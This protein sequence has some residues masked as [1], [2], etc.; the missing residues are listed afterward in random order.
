MKQEF[1]ATMPTSSPFS[2]FDP[3]VCLRAL[4]RS[5]LRIAVLAEVLK[6]ASPDEIVGLAPAFVREVATHREPRARRRRMALARTIDDGLVR[7]IL[8]WRALDGDSRAEVLR[9]GPERLLPVMRRL[10]GHSDPEA[11]F[12]VIR[13][14]VDMGDPRVAGDLAGLAGDGDVDVAR[15]AERALVTIARMAPERKDV[16]CASAASA[17]VD[18]ARRFGESHSS[19]GLLLSALLLTPPRLEGPASARQ[20][21]LA[22]WLMEADQ[23]GHSA[24]RTVLRRSPDPRVRLRAMHWMRWAPMS[25]SATARVGRAVGAE[26]HEVVLTVSHLVLHPV[27]AAG[28]RSAVVS[29]PRRSVRGVGSWPE[30]CALP[31]PEVAA[32]LSTAA[33]RGLARFAAVMAG[34]A[35]TLSV[36]LHHALADPDATVRWTAARTLPIAESADYCFDENPLV[37]RSTMLR[38]STVGDRS[39]VVSE[40]DARLVRLLTRHPEAAIRRLAKQEWARI[41]PW[42][43]RLASSRLAARRR[44]AAN[45]HGFLGEIQAAMRE[46]E[47]AVG[48]IMLVRALGIVREFEANLCAVV[49]GSSNDADSLRAIAAAVSAL[50]DLDSPAARATLLQCLGHH[51]DRVRANAVDALARRSLAPA[52]V[53]PHSLRGTLAEFKDDPSHRVRANAILALIRGVGRGI[54]ERVASPVVPTRALSAMLDDDRVMHRIA[55]LWVVDR[56]IAAGLDGRFGD[57]SIQIALAL[58]A[59]AKREGEVKVRERAAQCAGRLLSVTR[60]AWRRRAADVIVEP[61]ETSRAAA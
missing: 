22:K 45:R 32:T 49:R 56:T 12:V 57:A 43:H 10:A 13:A 24:L 59:M 6:I 30:E 31:H 26:D 11:R 9:L 52:E 14:M 5:T 28:L 53:E 3:S 60:H 41:D 61:K 17:V 19:R 16:T 15:G 21:P 8:A 25:V 38:R 39:L 23:P 54:G 34:D 2:H 50:G 20:S 47:R 36:A 58:D 37:A 48:T 29:V 35:T 18:A 44:L 55:G 33:R 4:R 46:C 7:V 51:D 40:G 42:D 27:R 1:R